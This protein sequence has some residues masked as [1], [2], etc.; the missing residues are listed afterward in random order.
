MAFVLLNLEGAGT[1]PNVSTLPGTPEY[2]DL[3][4]G[5]HGGGRGLVT[6]L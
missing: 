2:F 1:P 3:P 5:R 6:L 4:F